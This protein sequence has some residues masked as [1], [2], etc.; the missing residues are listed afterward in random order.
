ME[1]NHSVAERIFDNEDY[2]HAKANQNSPL[3]IKSRKEQD[4]LDIAQQQAML[5]K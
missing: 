4:M 5:L 2:E 3:L 1:H